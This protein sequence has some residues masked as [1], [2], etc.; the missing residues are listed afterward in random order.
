MERE[1]IHSHFHDILE[2]TRRFQEAVP[3]TYFSSMFVQC[4]WQQHSVNEL[5]TY[6]SKTGMEQ[7]LLQ[8]KS[9]SQA[10]LVRFVDGFLGY[11]VDQPGVT[12]DLLGES[13]GFVE[14]LF[15]WIH[16]TD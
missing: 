5:K 7:S 4:L 12:T 14:N 10:K 11:R 1:I 6:C 9:L 8:V 3:V 16:F 2:A 15:L 13:D